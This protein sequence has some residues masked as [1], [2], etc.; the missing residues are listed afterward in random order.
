MTKVKALTAKTGK[1]P[2]TTIAISNQLAH[3]KTNT[4]GRAQ[5]NVLTSLVK[6]LLEAM[7]GQT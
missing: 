7:E 1:R 4:S 6:S 3:E 2:T 5:I